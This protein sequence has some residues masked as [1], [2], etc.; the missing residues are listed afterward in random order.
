MVSS[1]GLRILFMIAR[2]LSFYTLLH[3][4]T[5]VTHTNK[6]WQCRYEKL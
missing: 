3:H 5:N 4:I 6:Y 2:L 1:A